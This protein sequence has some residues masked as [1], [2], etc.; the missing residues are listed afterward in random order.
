MIGR[1]LCVVS[2]MFFVARVTS[3]KIPAGED[4]IFGVNE[5]IQGLFNT[6]LLG[7]LMLT[8]MGSISWQLVAS[9]FPIAFLSNPITY[10]LLRWCLLL[11]ATGICQGA[12]VLASIHKKIAGFQRDEVYIGTAEERAKQDM[13]DDDKSLQLGAGHLVKL[14]GFAD[15]A[16]KQLQDLVA[17]DSS[18]EKYMNDI[19][20][21]MDN[22]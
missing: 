22:A 16:P 6:G 19:A 1:Q 4:N 18:V 8:I 17:K 13:G 12:W 5:G 2:C 9:A 10:F 20:D 14:P 11:E 15:G 7:A 3:V 21:R